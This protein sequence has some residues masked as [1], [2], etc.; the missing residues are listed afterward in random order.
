MKILV[1]F[2]YPPPPGGLATQGDLLLRGL[3]A[4]GVDARAAHLESALE[5]EW[6]Y[7]CF[8]PDAVV[9]IGY[10]G[11]TPHLVHHA[12]RHGVLAIPWLVANG[13][14]VNYR[15]TLE[16]LPLMLVTSQWV[17]DVYLRD[18]ISNR[19]IEVLPVGCDTENFVPYPRSDPR[20]QAARAALGV[21]EDQL[22][23][24]TIGGDA[25]SKGG[26]EVMAALASL[27][28]QIPDYRYVCKVWDQ[29]RTEKQNALDWELVKEL[30]IE[31]KVLLCGDRVS[32]QFMPFLLS[33]CD[34]YAAPSRL[35]GFGMSQVE[36]GA[37][38]KP[39]IGIRA[40]AMLETLIHGQTALLA[41]VAQENLATGATVGPEAGFAPGH[42]IE[43]PQPRVVDYRASVPDLAE[44][45]RTLLG[46]A[47]LRRRMGEAGRERAL[48]Y[49]YR[50]VA[51]RFIDIVQRKLGLGG[52]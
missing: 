46:D 32:R 49:D 26:R 16:Q 48:E 50:K 29:P 21:R 42:R 9:G 7:R 14:V 25:A 36:A 37:C 19:N 27:G 17:K 10:W 3:L 31:H 43:F 4:L 52:A 11:M 13:Y 5:K 1:L 30:G 23:I 47:A 33:A 34:V 44:H 45:L 41:G 22:L 39:V 35:E 12:Q 18:G 51:Q 6:Y 15:D 40:M 38:G 28:E 20:V 8:Q 2:D 24:L